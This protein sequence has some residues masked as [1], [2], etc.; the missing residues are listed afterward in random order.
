MPLDG[1]AV[2]EVAVDEV[3]DGEVTDEEVAADFQRLGVVA[4]VQ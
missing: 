4:I 2:D 1:V 3:A